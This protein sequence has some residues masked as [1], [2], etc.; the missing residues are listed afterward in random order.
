MKLL[1]F[2]IY[3][4]CGIVN[5]IANEKNYNFSYAGQLIWSSSIIKF[6]FNSSF[7]TDLVSCREYDTINYGY[8]DYFPIENIKDVKLSDDILRVNLFVLALRDA[9]I[10][11]SPTDQHEKSSAIYEIGKS[12]LVLWKL[13]Y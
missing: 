9:L 11:L 6:I 1:R 10:M 13:N 2:V 7:Q 5:G 3:F 12:K 4:M 8:H